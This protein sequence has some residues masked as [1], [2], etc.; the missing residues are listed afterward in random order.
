MNHCIF[1]G[2]LARDPDVKTL[3]SGKTRAMFTL[4]VNRT[5]LN[6]EGKRDADF[7]T[8]IAY[9]KT[10]ELVGKYLTKGRKAAVEARVRTGHYDKDGT[11][12]WTTDFI[13]DRVEF[14][15]PAQHDDGSSAAQ[16][17][18]PPPTEAPADN[19]GFTEVEEDE[20]PF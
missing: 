17:D 16:G 1:I 3:T 15:S 13:A 2:N 10:A 19:G 7:I 4:A 20:L 9:D 12:V 8:F 5:Y 6:Q 18:V 14:L 11:T